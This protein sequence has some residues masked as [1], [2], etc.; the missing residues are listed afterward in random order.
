MGFIQVSEGPSCRVVGVRV[1]EAGDVEALTHGIA[2]DLDYLD[3]GY[4]IAIV[5]GI[6]AGVA[7][8]D[9]ADDAPALG[10]GVAEKSAAALVRVGFFAVG[11][12]R[13]KDRL[14]DVERGHGLRQ[15]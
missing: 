9:S 4:L 14:R 7:G 11:A 6:S 8:A 13:I 15:V 10:R 1:V 12:D 2:L 3:G 5:G